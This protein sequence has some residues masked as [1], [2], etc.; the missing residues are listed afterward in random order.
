MPYPTG[1]INQAGTVDSIDLSILV[2]NWGETTINLDA[3]VASFTFTPANPV[4]GEPVTFDASLF[5]VGWS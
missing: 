2:S 1:D 4:T 5:A 3:P